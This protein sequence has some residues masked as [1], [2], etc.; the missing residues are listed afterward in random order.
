[1]S[2][3]IDTHAHV[4]PAVYLDLIE[5]AGA[6]PATTQIARNLNADSTDADISA[7]LQWM[8]T[9]G[10]ETQVLA[11]TPQVPRSRDTA[12]WINDDYARLI[13]AHPGRFAAYGA[14]PLP[15][16]D[17]ALTEL[18]E[19]LARGFV[20]ISLPTVFA[21]GTTLDDPSFAPLWERAN[22]LSLVV[23]IH[24]TGSGACS[25]LIADKG[26]TWVNGALV[27]DATA[28]LHLLKAQVPWR[29]P[30]IR[31]HVAHLGGDL[32]YMFQRLEDNYTDWGAFIGSPQQALRKFFFDAA[33]F[34]E[35]ALRLAVE[36]YG[37][38]QILAGSD[39]P[40]FQ[41]EYYVRAFE[42][43]RTAKLPEQVRAQILRGNALALYADRWP[44]AA[45]HDAA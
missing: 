27:E 37:D 23:N 7:R 14:L 28:T 35:P 39:M 24:P 10:V 3:A 40:Y 38:T 31:F 2:G 42:Y 32:A 11:V 6:D 4:Y 13:A 16:I 30:Q 19:V 15:D 17:T 45:Q 25:P 12:R 20:G 34:Y 26:L 29:Y 8:D 1:M 5:Q 21:D 18:D 44:A 9:A 36:S 43:V 41:Q 22:E 33:N